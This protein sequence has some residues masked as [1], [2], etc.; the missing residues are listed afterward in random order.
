MLKMELPEAQELGLGFE[1]DHRMSAGTAK[2]L[3]EALGKSGKIRRGGR[4]VDLSHRP[5]MS[6]GR[7]RPRPKAGDAHSVGR[8]RLSLLHHGHS[9]YHR[10]HANLFAARLINAFGFI[11][12][13]RSDL[14]RREDRENR[15]GAG[16]IGA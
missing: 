2:T 11:L 6:R 5:R 7:F 14:A 4:I 8:R 10:L 3:V 12:Q 15:E 16:R 1:S 9:H 13:T